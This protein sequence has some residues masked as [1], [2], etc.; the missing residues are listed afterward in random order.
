MKCAQCPPAGRIINKHMLISV[1]ILR[2][3]IVR[4]FNR[5]DSA[6]KRCCLTAALMLM[7]NQNG[8]TAHGEGGDRRMDGGREHYIAH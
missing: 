2:T 8:A 1:L 7:I 3:S 5:A 4:D 6:A